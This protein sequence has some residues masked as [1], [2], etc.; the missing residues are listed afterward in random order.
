MLINF[1]AEKRILLVLV[2]LTACVEMRPK[3]DAT[4]DVGVPSVD[5]TSDM[6]PTFDGDVLHVDIAATGDE[7][8]VDQE[9]A[10]TSIQA[11]LDLLGALDDRNGMTVLVYPGIY[12]EELNLDD[13]HSGIKD[14]TNTLRA[15]AKGVQITGGQ[16]GIVLDNVKYFVLEGFQVRDIV[17]FGVYIRES[18]FLVLR[19]L[20]VER[21]G[22]SG[23]YF[24]AG[25]SDN[26][27]EDF[28]VSEARYGVRLWGPSWNRTTERNTVRRGEMVGCRFSGL[29]VEFT[30]DSTF[31][32]LVVHGSKEDA[33]VLIDSESAGNTFDE[34]EVYG[35]INTGM[36]VSNSS[37]NLFSN[38]DLHD[39]PQINKSQGGL[40]LTA[41][42]NDNQFS[43]VECHGNASGV[44]LEG[45]ST[46]NTFTNLLLHNNLAYGMLL[47][48]A[49]NNSVSLSTIVFNANSGIRTLAEANNTQITNSLISHNG[50][51]GEAGLRMDATASGF[52]SDYNTVSAL[53]RV[54]TGVTEADF[55]R[56]S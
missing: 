12:E 50:K 9:N 39:N 20:R 56:A 32:Q 48:N 25:S 49:A 7:T 31:E 38:L 44:F 17:Q 5:T 24:F 36:R 3:P 43:A 1:A 15:A 21:C 46:G 55:V 10:F 53:P 47:I 2:L 42:A 26:L 4:V 35:N 30:E 33:G 16:M 41:E 51:A 22:Y 29:M 13:R 45:K 8:G 28:Y 27:L 18:R 54:A 6:P 37:K 34:L 23:I 40:H 19:N 14:A 11:A 52:T